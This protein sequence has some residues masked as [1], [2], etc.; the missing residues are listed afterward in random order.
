MSNATRDRM[1]AD[2]KAVH[3]AMLGSIQL[4]LTDRAIKTTAGA[5]LSQFAS[6]HFS[7]ITQLL[8][9]LT[10]RTAGDRYVFQTVVA[11]YARRVYERATA[12]FKSRMSAVEA[13]EE[14][15]GYVLCSG[16]WPKIWS[17]CYIRSGEFKDT[18]KLSCDWKNSGCYSSCG[19]GLCEFGPVPFAMGMARDCYQRHRE[20]VA[21]QTVQ[22]WQKWLTPLPI[23]LDSIAVMQSIPVK[24]TATPRSSGFDSSAF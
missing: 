19:L 4:F 17:F 23:W 11:C 5:Y 12:A 13:H 7:V 15:R 9:S 16:G 10:Y 24:P 1:Y 2:L 22:F 6:L 8:G 14:D 18:W 3:D 20:A 21:N